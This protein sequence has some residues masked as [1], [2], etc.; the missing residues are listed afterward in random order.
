MYLFIAFARI[1]LFK[2]SERAHE[3]ILIDKRRQLEE[4]L[5]S[6]RLQRDVCAVQVLLVLP[7]LL[8]IL[9]HCAPTRSTN[10]GICCFDPTCLCILFGADRYYERVY[11]STATRL[12][13]DLSGMCISLVVPLCY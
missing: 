12:E 10:R 6:V 2:P 1:R 11:V 3:D 8:L 9:R 5:R 7:I 4:K 13:A